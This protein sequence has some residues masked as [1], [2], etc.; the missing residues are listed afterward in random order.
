M[1]VEVILALTDMG[2]SY[3]NMF[4]GDDTVD[5]NSTNSTILDDD[6]TSNAENSAAGP[7]RQKVFVCVPFSQQLR[8]S[9]VILCKCVDML[10][11]FIHKLFP[12]HGAYPYKW[13]RHSECVM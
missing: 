5:T 9:I 13:C 4:S 6:Q 2:I 3:A 10:V 8:D 7:L 1:P 11:L 12:H